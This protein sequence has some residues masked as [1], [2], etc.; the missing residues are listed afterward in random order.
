MRKNNISRRHFTIS[1]L[2]TLAAPSLALSDNQPKSDFSSDLQLQIDQAAAE[3]RKSNNPKWP[4]TEGYVEIPPGAYS[5]NKPIR[6]RSGVRVFSKNQASTIFLCN[7]DDAGPLFYSDPSDELY[8]TKLSGFHAIDL[9]GHQ[10]D[11]LKIYNANR[12][13]EIENIFLEHFR[14]GIWAENCF[15]MNLRD[16]G[17][18]RCVN[19]I[20]GRNLTNGRLDSIKVENCFEN[21]LYLLPSETNTTTGTRVQGFVAQGN[22]RYGVLIDSLDHI[23]FDSLFL[24]GNNRPEM[25]ASDDRQD[26]AQICITARDNNNKNMKNGSIAFNSTFITRGHS[27]IKNTKAIIIEQAISVQFRSGYFRNFSQAYASAFDIGTSVQSIHLEDLTLE[28]FRKDQVAN[29]STA[30]SHERIHLVDFNGN[31]SAW[32]DR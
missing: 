9:R 22:G 27:K 31:V 20:Y 17:I 4:H 23:E 30:L 19:G 2:S 7:I 6:L 18:Y 1:C 29:A 32:T 3:V 24:E 16:I 21:G 28:G 14:F 10:S 26:Y 13:C 11:F 15:T 12:N 25:R 8:S 5:V